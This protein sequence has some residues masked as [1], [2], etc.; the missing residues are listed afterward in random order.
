LQRLERW[1]KRNQVVGAVV[2]LLSFL[3]WL[4]WTAKDIIAG[5]LEQLQK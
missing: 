3:G 1:A 5:M 2:T 4:G